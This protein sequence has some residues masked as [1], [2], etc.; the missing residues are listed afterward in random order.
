MLRKKKYK[1]SSLLLVA[2]LLFTLIM[3]GCQ[4]TEQA[5]S[6]SEQMSSEQQETTENT[7][8]EKISMKIATLKGPTGMGLV[9]L[10]EKDELGE[11]TLDYEFSVL[12]SPDDLV[13]KIV[14]GEVDAATIPTNLAAVLYQKTQGNIRIAAVNTLG[15][16]YVV[17][18]GDTIHSVADLK[19]KTIGSSGKGA[20]PDFVFRYILE[21]NGLDPEK[22]VTLDYKM[23]HADLSAALAEGDVAI[24]L[25]PQPHVTAA[26]MKNPDLQ[27]ALNITE[28]WKSVTG[29]KELPM[30]A[31]IVSKDFAENHKAEL[32]SFLN[33]YE[34]SV[35]YVN[36]QS[37]EA[38]ALIEKFEILPKAAVAKKAIPLCNITY[39][40][41]E[42]AKEFLKEFYQILFDFEAKSV[43]GKLPDDEFYY[44]K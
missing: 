5:V 24:A 13:G 16:L 9:Q 38:S 39:I 21:K 15:V 12:G 6:D 28:E 23:Q 22:D 41:A 35:A 4:G 19:G 36:E 18:K 25:L 27:V 11:A 37:E 42:N 34:Q 2:L 1:N 29:D 7:N 31:L 10:M 3:G 32:D 17:E 20:A 26:M 40:E 44:K 43:G 14:S 33:E 8:I 30:G